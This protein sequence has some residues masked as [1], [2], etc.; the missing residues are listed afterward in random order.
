MRIEAPNLFSKKKSSLTVLL[1][2]ANCTPQHPR[3]DAD[4]AQ[5]QSGRAFIFTGSWKSARSRR[6]LKA[7]S[8]VVDAGTPPPTVVPFPT[9]PPNVTLRVEINDRALGR[10]VGTGI[11]CGE[12]CLATFPPT[13]LITLRALPSRGGVFAGWSGSEC[14]EGDPQREGCTLKMNLERSVSAQFTPGKILSIS[15]EPPNG[16]AVAANGKQCAQ[17]CELTLSDSSVVTLEAAPAAGK[18]FFGWDGEC[19][20]SQPS[21]QITMAKARSV[22][23]IFRDEIKGDINSDGSVNQGDIVALSELLESDSP[24]YRS[25][26]DID[27]DGLI[28]SYDL[29]RLTGLVAGTIPLEVR[30]P[31]RHLELDTFG[32]PTDQ[33]DVEYGASLVE[34]APSLALSWNVKY[35]QKGASRAEE[36]QPPVMNVSFNKRQSLFRGLSSYPPAGGSLFYQKVRFV[37]NCDIWQPPGGANV[38]LREYL[39]YNIFR[40]FGVP[41]NDTIGFAALR[42]HG[43]DNGRYE[44]STKEYAYL[45]LQRDNEKDDQVPFANQFSLA[46]NLFEA[47]EGYGGNSDLARYLPGKFQGVG[48]TT[49]TQS[50]YLPLDPE[51]SIRHFLTADF[52][53]LDDHQDP[54][55]NEDYGCPGTLD[56]AGNCSAPWKT[57]PFDFDVAVSYCVDE[58]TGFDILTEIEKLPEELRPEYRQIY[59]RVVREIFDN[60]DSL[61]ELL[62]TIDRYPFNVERTTLKHF[63][64]ARFLTLAKRFGSPE[65]A[66][67]VAQPHV[68]FVHRARFLRELERLAAP[69]TPNT[70]FVAACEARNIVTR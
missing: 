40:R 1:C 51:N 29:F 26:A 30:H 24:A 8:F 64:K 50:V 14:A 18:R 58:P 44:P 43:S 4:L 17:E 20:D 34:H 59:Y 65:F 60:P 38:L 69:L 23:A 37:P 53:Y 13:Q 70:Q 7:V 66:A 68:D 12:D 62:L 45:L 32:Q 36:C 11:E 19:L 15:I 41:T 6:T 33:L 31:V 39:G 3:I 28:D 27:D 22:R 55:R 16:G 67:Q 47:D 42:I 9:L 48:F 54:F 25:D 5:L 10:V 52:L 57:I 35:K 46:L 63:I 21:C 61:N 2:V 56:A 49:A